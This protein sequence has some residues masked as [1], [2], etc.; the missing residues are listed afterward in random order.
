M[1][2]EL[3]LVHVAESLSGRPFVPN[4]RIFLQ[5]L[6]NFAVRAIQAALRQLTDDGVDR[7]TLSVI[8]SSSPISVFVESYAY[9]LWLHTRKQMS[10]KYC[11]RNAVNND[12]NAGCGKHSLQ[13][14]ADRFCNR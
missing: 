2:R 6:G 14:F 9:Q 7:R 10:A 13:G 4:F 11:D 3:G 5:A 8:E 12:T 1:I